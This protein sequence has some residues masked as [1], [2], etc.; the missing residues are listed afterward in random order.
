MEEIYESARKDLIELIKQTEEEINQPYFKPNGNI[1]KMYSLIECLEKKGYNLS[2]ERDKL[3]K[4][5]NKI[6]ILC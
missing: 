1:T 4:I 3:N 5:E 2:R 6:K